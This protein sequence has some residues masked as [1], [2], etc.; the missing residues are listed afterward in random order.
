MHR[1]KFLTN[2]FLGSVLFLSP[3]STLPALAAGSATLSWDPNSESDLEHYNVYKGMASG[4]YGFPENAE[5]S[6]SKG[7]VQHQMGNLQEGEKHFF[8]VT[9]VDRAGNESNP[10]QEVSKLIP[11]PDDTGNTDDGG[12]D[13]GGSDSNTGGNDATKVNL[14]VKVRGGGSVTSNPP[15]I[16]CSGGTCTGSFSSGSP[17]TLTHNSSSGVSFE[18]WGGA[19]CKRAGT[20]HCTVKLQNQTIVYAVFNNSNAGS[21]SGG[22]DTNGDDSNTGGNNTEKMNLVVKV[23]GGGTVTSNPPGIN[24]SKGMC[25][26]SFT[27]N[28]KVTLTPSPS[29]NMSFWRWGGA[30]CKRA[31]TGPCTVK[32]NTTK[33][34][35]GTF[36][37]N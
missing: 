24:C 37:S 16:N 13:S 21:S 18:R 7:R 23:H 26:A 30:P 25:S 32:L 35:Y 27:E 19:A 12:N 2:C 3:F 20:G 36:R 1:S 5:K 17:I 33:I 4:Q 15:G 34:V 29:S 22:N 11:V 9:A 6:V 10:S 28:T 31:G 14:V 8:T